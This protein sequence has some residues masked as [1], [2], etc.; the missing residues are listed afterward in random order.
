MLQVHI[1][2]C[3]RNVSYVAGQF[4]IFSYCYGPENQRDYNSCDNPWSYKL[5]YEMVNAATILY[6]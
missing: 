1:H 2:D 3:I 6:S 4:L 5:S